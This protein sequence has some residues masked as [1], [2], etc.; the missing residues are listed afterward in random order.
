MV[1]FILSL[2]I[3]SYGLLGAPS[4]QFSA[5]TI[6]LAMPDTMQASGNAQ[7]E[8]NNIRL[9]AQQFQYNIDTQ[10]GQFN[11]G[12]VITHNNATLKGDQFTADILKNKI[13]GHR[14]IELTTPSIQATS[15]DLIIENGAIL[16]LLNNVY[17]KQN[18]SQIK[19]NQLIYNLK[20][21]TIIS[22]KRTKFTIKE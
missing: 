2:I 22:N 15:D 4:I 18:G 13:T 16:T 17:I 3:M 11:I 20:T 8:Y 1:Q 14:N 9:R 12:V 6:T 19:S 21:D 10:T 7:F 5:D